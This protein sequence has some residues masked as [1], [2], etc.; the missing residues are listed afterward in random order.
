MTESDPPISL[1]E[2]IE[3]EKRK[4]AK[5]VEL[6]RL[7]AELNFVV[8][9]APGQPVHSIAPAKNTIGKPNGFDGTV[10]GL[11]R[12]YQSE[13]RST[14]HQLKFAVRKHYDGT[15]KRLTDDIGSERV[16]ELD[17]AKIKHFYDTNWAA[18]G[19]LAMGHTMVGKLRM[20]STF[21]STVL[22][23]DGCTHLAGVLAHM[24]FESA[25]PRTERLTAEH[26]HS[27]RS[28]A[29]ETGRISIAIAQAFQFEEPRLRQADIIGEW[30]PIGEPGTSEVMWQK[31]KWLR[32][33]RWSEIDENMILH[34]TIMT[35]RR[36]NRREEIEI[37]LSNKPMILEEL[38]SGRGSK[39][40]RSALPASGPIVVS[41][42]TRLPYHLEDFRRKWRDIA[43]GAGVP[44]EVRNSDSIR[45]DAQQGPQRSR[46]T[47]PGKES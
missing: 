29:R 36:K 21:G 16:A 15:L 44:P 10:G 31:Q 2:M 23:D 25:K 13:K 24:H 6:Q 26:A 5:M 40:D 34:R 39:I 43:D 11:V 12:S 46:A 14:Y 38:F 33:L 42:T 7:A 22:K 41:E 32:G 1:E 19:K 18:G 17:A 30:V 37:D 47:I 28:K 35:G 27:I 20:L 3:Q 8:S 45:A 9:A 4:L